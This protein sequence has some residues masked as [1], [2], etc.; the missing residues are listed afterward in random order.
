MRRLYIN[1]GLVC[2]LFVL[3][4]FKPCPEKSTFRSSV[5]KTSEDNMIV[6]DAPGASSAWSIEVF[7]SS[8]G[9]I[10][11]VSVEKEGHT[12]T[13]TNLNEGEYFL[14]LENADGCKVVLGDSQDILKGI[15][16]GN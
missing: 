3:F 11:D 12:I 7:H 8:L 14:K 6:I 13:L 2:A 10:E 1:I 16:V 9:L 5:V 15:T 4:A